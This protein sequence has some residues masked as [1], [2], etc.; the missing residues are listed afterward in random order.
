MYRTPLYKPPSMLL[1]AL[2]HSLRMSPRLLTYFSSVSLISRTVCCRFEM[3]GATRLAR[4]E[5]D[6]A[7]SLPKCRRDPRMSKLQLFEDDRNIL[8]RASRTR[9]RQ[10]DATYLWNRWTAH[11]STECTWKKSGGK[12]AYKM[13]DQ[14]NSA[15]QASQV[16]HFSSG[17]G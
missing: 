10:T 4:F 16:A 8:T 2:S 11:L 5:E 3:T 12:S 6:L 9:R 15:R 7:D 1:V 14:A 17:T 13:A